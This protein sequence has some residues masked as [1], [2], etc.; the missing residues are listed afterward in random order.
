MA[1]A[2][3][4]LISIGVLAPL[5]IDD[6]KISRTDLGLLVS[7]A[8][9]VSALLSPVAGRIV[10]RIGD[11]SA[12]LIVFV[13]GAASLT[14]MAT[15]ASYA[16]LAAA[17]A[18]AGFCHAGSNPATNRLIS[19]RVPRGR[20]GF[21]TGIKQ[22]GETIAIV[23]AASVLP[24]TAVWLGWRAAVIVL[25]GGALA[26]LVA[27]S[28][29]I[30]GS[31][32]SANVGGALRATPIR[33]SIYWLSGYSFAMGAAGGAVTTYLPL[34]AHDIGGL[35]VAAAGSVMV[36][37]GLVAT[38]CRI[39]A[40]R[41]TELRLGVPLALLGL[42]VLA[43]LSGVL[44]IAAPSLGVGAFWWAAALWGAS[45]LTFGSVGM[46]AVM[47]ESDDSNTGRAS[48]LTVLGFGAGLTS[49]PPLFGWLVDQGYGYDAGFLVVTGFYAV[50]VAVMLLGRASF[51]DVERPRV[52]RA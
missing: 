3:L 47:A 16:A 37:A 30:Q 24:V 20:R 12:L 29:G 11:R 38:V 33:P 19:G 21:I 51:L 44:L 13:A 8:S 40:S 52:R 50:A 9:G 45:G 41:W 39:V 5:L 48:G 35:S 36:V 25:A 4:P 23:L 43:V 22:S 46:L 32:R 17:L 18:I 34:Y 1:V 31:R 2:I 42:A 7:V 49:T 6:L 10:D 27:A 14:C 28:I 26:A 15:A